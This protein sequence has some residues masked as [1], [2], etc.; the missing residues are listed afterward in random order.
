MKPNDLFGPNVQV[1]HFVAVVF[2]A[3]IVLAV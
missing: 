2:I 3:Q 1:W